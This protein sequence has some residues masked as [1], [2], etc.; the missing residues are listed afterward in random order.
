MC[1]CV[2]CK[3][4]HGRS[5][6]VYARFDSSGGEGQTK[7]RFMN[8][9]NTVRFSLGVCEKLLVACSHCFQVLIL[10]EIQAVCGVWESLRQL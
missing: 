10:Q 7:E 9:S 6:D 3:V 2:C 5:A 8:C 4:S 1:V